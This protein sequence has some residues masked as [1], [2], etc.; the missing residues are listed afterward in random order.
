MGE[1]LSISGD[2][3]LL[4]RSLASTLPHSPSKTAVPSNIPSLG[5]DRSPD[6]P[7]CKAHTRVS[8]QSPP[9]APKLLVSSWPIAFRMRRGGSVDVEQ[10]H[11]S[12]SVMGV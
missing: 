8:L 3:N 6:Y 10:M 1:T 4:V 12:M 7:Y 2:L 9:P 11:R 5:M